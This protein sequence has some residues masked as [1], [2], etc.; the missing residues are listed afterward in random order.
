MWLTMALR[1]SLAANELADPPAR[2][3]RVIG[4]HGEIALVLAHDL[5]DDA[6]GRAHAP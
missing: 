6:L 3:R 2:H 1:S 4:D 5:I